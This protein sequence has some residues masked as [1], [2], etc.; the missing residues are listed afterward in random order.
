MLREVESKHPEFEYE[1][2]DFSDK[3]WFA[4]NM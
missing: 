3:Y 2:R 1:G 4:I